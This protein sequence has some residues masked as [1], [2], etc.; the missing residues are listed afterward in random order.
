MG[1]SLTQQISIKV[2]LCT[3]LCTTIAA[4]TPLLLSLRRT[5][6][7]PKRGLRDEPAQPHFADWKAEVYSPGDI[8]QDKA[9]APLT[10]RQAHSHP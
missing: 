3:K 4:L 2:L 8:V 5:R 10:A 7:R 1:P 9:V 6:F